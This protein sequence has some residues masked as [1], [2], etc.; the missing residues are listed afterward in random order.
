MFYCYFHGGESCDFS[1]LYSGRAVKNIRLYF[2][3]QGGESR[4]L[5]DRVHGNSCRYSDKTCTKINYIST[6]TYSIIM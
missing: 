3:N 2:F 6:Y 1:Y 4:G 5:N